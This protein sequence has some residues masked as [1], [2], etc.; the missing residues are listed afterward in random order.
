M[1]ANAALFLND[2]F[3]HAFSAN[4]FDAMEKL[5]ARELPVLCV[6]PG[7][8]A[9]TEYEAI[10]ES[11]RR[12]LRNPENLAVAPHHARVFGYGPVATVCCYEQVQGRLFLAANTFAYENGELRIVQHHASHCANPPAPEE[13]TPP[14]L[15]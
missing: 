12:I 4:D 2:A 7:W 15:Q 5:W 9:L 11:W 8:P 1:D 13:R 3:Y 14:P 6:H 10:M